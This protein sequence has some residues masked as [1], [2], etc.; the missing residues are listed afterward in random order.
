MNVAIKIRLIKLWENFIILLSLYVL[1]ELGYEIIYPLSEGAVQVINTIDF[2]ICMI[3]LSDFFYF[4]HES[5]NKKAYLRKYWIDLVAS[6]PFMTL[7]RFFRVVRVIRIIR[8]AR[9]IK[10]LIPIV[11]KIGTSKS[12]NILIAY[13]LILIIVMLYCSLAFFEFEKLSNSNIHT[14]FDAFWWAFVTTTTIGY[15]DIFPVTTEGRIIGMILALLGMGLFSLITAE[16][17]SRF[18]RMTKD[19]DQMIINN[20]Y[21][22]EIEETDQNKN[23]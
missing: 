12:Q 3:F 5:E 6:I 18:V 1:I 23:S 21:H 15:G 20:K 9:G 2:I 8:L 14:F 7:F 17:A 4:L 10:A 11:R 16:L 22:D 19:K 13:I